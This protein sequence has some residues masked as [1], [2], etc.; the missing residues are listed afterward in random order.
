MD[1][2]KK[3]LKECIPYVIIIIVVV[4]IKMT[5]VSPIKVNGNSMK[6]TLKDGD[7]MIL[8]MIGYK[9]SKVK[10]FD[11]VVL[12]NEKDYIIKRV[13]GLPGEIIEYHDNKLYV[14][15]KLVK[16]KYGNGHTND[17]SVEVPKD[18]YFVLGDNRGDS[19]DSRY[20][21]SFNKKKILGK[22]NFTVFPFNRFGNKK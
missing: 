15:G 14:D 20:F 17:F 21:G 16:D 8:N 2:L 6:N 3:I 10:R 1:K 22:T 5:I 7:I 9:T 18:S 19:L 13:I 4:I 11:I 12:D